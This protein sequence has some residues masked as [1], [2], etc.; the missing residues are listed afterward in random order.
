MNDGRGEE[1]ALFIHTVGR[2]RGSESSL[3]RELIGLSAE[4]VIPDDAIYSEVQGDWVITEIYRCSC[5][6]VITAGAI[7]KSAYRR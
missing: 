3:I 6:Y 2:L 5:Y 7:I 4:R 1:D